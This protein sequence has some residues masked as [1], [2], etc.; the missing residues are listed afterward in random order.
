MIK[1][2]GILP[3]AYPSF[4]DEIEVARRSSTVPL[5]SR[6]P[7]QA[8][9]ST[10]TEV[11]L[12]AMASAYPVTTARCATLTPMMVFISGMLTRVSAVNAIGLSAW[13]V[14]AVLHGNLSRS[15]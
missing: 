2:R 13:T 1:E 6:P 8:P 9:A 3:F 14:H 15:F 4:F 7:T 11:V 12:M 10:E 5:P